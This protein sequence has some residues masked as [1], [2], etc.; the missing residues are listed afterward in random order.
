[1]D[2]EQ[3]A[4]EENEKIKTFLDGQST[5]IQA[6][7]KFAKILLD[8]HVVVVGDPGT[9]ELVYNRKHPNSLKAGNIF[10]DMKGALKAAAEFFA[11][12]QKPD[13]GLHAVQ[14]IL[15][16]IFSIKDLINIKLPEG[17]S[18]IIILLN[19]LGA[20]EYAVEEK[21]LLQRVQSFEQEQVLEIIDKNKLMEVVIF[22]DKYG[23]IEI[24]DGKVRLKEKVF[25]KDFI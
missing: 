25:G 17:S 19:R 14:L 23:V 4:Y 2:A 10:V 24:L 21:E 16:L 7:K 18:E 22:L 6:D 8:E 1:M 15:L 5:L 9:L 11:G 20:Y 13:N 12:Y 3:R